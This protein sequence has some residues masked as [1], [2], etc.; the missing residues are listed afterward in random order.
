MSALG[1]ADLQDIAGGNWPDGRNFIPPLIRNLSVD[2]KLN[3][4]NK[5]FSK[6]INGFFEEKKDITPLSQLTST[7]P[8][9]TPHV[10]AQF[11]SNTYEDYKKR[12]TDAQ[13]E[14]R[15]ALPDGWEL[16]TTASNVSKT[17]GYFGAAYWQL[18]H[19][20]VVIAH[21]GTDPTNVG[22]L[23]TNLNGV[24]RNQFVRQMESASTFA[25][26]VVEVLQTVSRKKGVSFQ[27]FFTGHSLG[28]WLAQITTFTTEYLK[29]ENNIFLKSNND[30]DYFHPHT[31][32]FDSPGCKRMLSQMKDTFDVRHGGRSIAS[33]H[34]DITSYLSSPNRINT[35]NKHVGTLYRIFPDLSDTVLFVSPIVTVCRMITN[36]SDEVWLTAIIGTVCRLFIYC[37]DTVWFT[38]I[39]GPVYS[40][41]FYLSVTVLLNSLGRP[42][43]RF[44]SYLSDRV[45]HIMRFV[46]Y[47]LETHSIDKIVQAFDPETGQVHKN[48]QGQLKVQVIRDWPISTGLRGGAEY[49]K[50]FEWAE[51]FKNYFPV[52][53]DESFRCLNYYPF[54]YQTALYDE[55]VKILSVFSQEEQEFIKSYCSLRGWLGVCKSKELFSIMEDS[56]FK[57]QAEEILQ[58][59][60]IEEDTLR[61][62][63]AS[64]LQKLI[65]YVKRLL[66]LFPE[67][68]EIRDR[69]Y[70]LETNSFIEQFYESP[71]EFKPDV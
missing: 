71:L 26:A 37:P 65:P 15:L 2:D 34:L 40:C 41:F 33:K 14:T 5:K 43:C 70:L 27:L 22:D 68:K 42:V 54:R 48:E 60:E 19:Q 57:S 25:N 21:R 46:L 12:E 58:S 61:C 59:F 10:L 20:Q 53:T 29:T 35:C 38:G 6:T 50:L 4:S 55:G 45:W 23:W 62:T 30:Q 49:K 44:L 17:N 9:P 16:L 47:T 7:P 67:I 13:Y 69:V 52:I 66:Q 63:D 36:L 11:A 64:A 1:N 31:I 32:V 28:G 18:E 39:M 3:L 51:K 8:F 24:M 56:Q